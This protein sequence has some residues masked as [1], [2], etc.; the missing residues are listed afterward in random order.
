MS[1]EQKKPKV[2]RHRDI[3]CKREC[4]V[5][6]GGLNLGSKF[7][8]AFDASLSGPPTKSIRLIWELVLNIKRS[9]PQVVEQHLFCIKLETN[10][11]CC[12]LIRVALKGEKGINLI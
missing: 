5:Y 1:E 9:Q 7:T 2:M 6:S 4:L 8:K 11:Q 3:F 10:S 12:L